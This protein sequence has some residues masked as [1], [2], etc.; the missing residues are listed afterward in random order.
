MR[1]LHHNVGAVAAILPVV[2]SGASGETTAVSSDLDLAGFG[3]AE[4]VV[5]IGVSGDT[6]ATNQKLVVTL[7]HAADDNGSPGSYAAPAAADVLGATPDDDGVVLTIDDPA[8]DAAVYRLGYVGSG[9]FLKLTIEAVG[10]HNNGTPICA[11]LIKGSPASAPV[12]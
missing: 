3:S 5:S 6:L 10:T 1:D 4:I 9:R 8:E 11:V 7:E 2:V 12:A